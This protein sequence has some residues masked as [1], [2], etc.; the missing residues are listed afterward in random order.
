MHNLDQGELQKIMGFKEKLSH[1]DNVKPKGSYQKM[2]SNHQLYQQLREK[3]TQK[4]SESLSIVDEEHKKCVKIYQQIYN[5][6][7]KHT[8]LNLNNML[9]LAQY[10]YIL[11]EMHLRYSLYEKLQNKPIDSRKRILNH[12]CLINDELYKEFILVGGFIEK[13]KKLI[14]QLFG[15][16]N[17]PDKKLIVS[18]LDE[19]GFDEQR[20]SNVLKV[21]Q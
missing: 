20:I 19:L 18:Y 16:F 21:I 2:Q 12:I 9:S 6:A 10:K 14:K 5:L 11:E 8:K 13:P 17:S 3:L 4:D 15:I 1:E 7:K